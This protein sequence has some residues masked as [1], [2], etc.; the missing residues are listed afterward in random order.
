MQRGQHPF[1]PAGQVGQPFSERCS[2]LGRPRGSRCP[3]GQRADS[4]SY[5]K[6]CTCGAVGGAPGS[7]VTRLVWAP[8]EPHWGRGGETIRGNG[9]WS[10][11]PS[12]SNAFGLLASKYCELAGQVCPKPLGSR[13]AL[14]GTSLVGVASVAGVT[15]GV[16]QLGCSRSVASAQK[17]ICPQQGADLETFPWLPSPT[18]VFIFLV[19]NQDSPQRGGKW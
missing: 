14:S 19:P 10:G 8:D 9:F 3:P 4:S 13:M 15:A 17:L 12:A 1:H 2:S 11:L 18:S 5:K 7:Q 6:H 16:T